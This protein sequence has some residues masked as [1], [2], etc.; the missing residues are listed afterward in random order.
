MPITT[1]GHIFTKVINILAVA[2]IW[3]MITWPIL[4][5]S[6]IRANEQLVISK[7]QQISQACEKFKAVNHAY[8]KDL[9]TLISFIREDMSSPG[10]NFI[11]NRTINDEYILLAS[12]QF[13]GL[14]GQNG[15]YSD[16][17]Q[18]ILKVKKDLMPAIYDSLV[19]KESKPVVLPPSG[20]ATI[21]S[22]NTVSETQEKTVPDIALATET[23]PGALPGVIP[24]EVFNALVANLEATTLSFYNPAVIKN[25]SY[26][27]LDRPGSSVNPGSVQD[28]NSNVP[29]KDTKDKQLPERK[30]PNLETEGKKGK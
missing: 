2:A 18:D 6:Q 24:D 8:P 3:L 16:N 14:T 23:T 17:G 20:V 30:L 29:S 11:Y 15:F 4:V 27:A 21:L 13:S 19:E 7:I 5:N 9:P 10:Y 22:Y 25:E 28:P 26:T 12:P 1:K